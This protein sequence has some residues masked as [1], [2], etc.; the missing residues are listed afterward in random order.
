MTAD[1]YPRLLADVGGTNARFAWKASPDAALSHIGSWLCN[2][3]D[4]LQ[5]AIQHHLQVHGLAQPRA[6]GI[7]IANPITGDQVRMTNHHWSFSIAQLQ[8]ALGVEKL[9]VINDFTAIALSLPSLSPADLRPIGGGQAVAGAPMAVLGPGTGLGVSGLLPTSS[10]Q[11]AAINGEGGHVT[12]AAGDAEEAA[13]I[14]HL[15]HR[16]GHVSVE[17]VLSGP[18]LVNLYEATADL[19]GKTVLALAP[20]DIVERA[21][22][23]GDV[24]CA[25]ALGH[26]CALLGSVAGNLALTLGARGGVFLAGGMAPRILGELGSAPFRQRFEGKGRFSNYLAQIP[27]FVIVG[28]VS[29][30]LTGVSRALDEA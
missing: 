26:F 7:G 11:W 14:E 12:L 23:H 28:D 17:R 3:H 22:H 9:V 5:H 6:C 2:E 29:P 1:R 8:Q 16:F 20:A 18:G 21:R 13:L 19:A 24:I 10:G 27:T 25:K 30:A 4:S 15:R